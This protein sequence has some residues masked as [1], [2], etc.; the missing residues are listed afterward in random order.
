[1]QETSNHHK[2]SVFQL[3]L[4]MEKVAEGELPKINIYRKQKSF[5]GEIKSFSHI[6]MV[7]LVR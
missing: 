2:Y 1:M 4:W 3:P 6:L 5:L 7:F